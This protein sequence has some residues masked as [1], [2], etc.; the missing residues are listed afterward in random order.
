MRELFN[1]R[2]WEGEGE[3]A[4]VESAYVIA[5]GDS[6]IKTNSYSRQGHDSVFVQ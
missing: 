6:P 4:K 5:I 2:K 1:I 3:R